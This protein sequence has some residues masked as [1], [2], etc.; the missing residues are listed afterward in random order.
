MFSDSPIDEHQLTIDRINARYADLPMPRD[1]PDNYHNFDL[2][3]L[4]FDN[5][6][7][8]SHEEYMKILKFSLKD[9]HH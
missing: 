1:Y 3:N 5:Q 6:Y 7:L 2:M 8:Y 9:L 4:D